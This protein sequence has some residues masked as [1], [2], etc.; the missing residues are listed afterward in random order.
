MLTQ[1]RATVADKAFADMH[2]KRHGTYE[3]FLHDSGGSLSARR[4]VRPIA[5]FGALRDNRA[6]M[7]SGA[8]CVA[9]ERVR[10]NVSRS[11]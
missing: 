4:Q 1:V 11:A 2:R 7:T 9:T 10:A 6:D 3:F 8:G 5:A